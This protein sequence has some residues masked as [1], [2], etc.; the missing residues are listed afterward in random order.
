M[1]AQ[2]RRDSVA[3][4]VAPILQSA[5][6]DT[7]LML[8]DSEADDPRRLQQCERMEQTIRRLT[9]D[10]IP[11]LRLRGPISLRGLREVLQ[12]QVGMDLQRWR[13]LIKH[14]AEQAVDEWTNEG[15]DGPETGST[16]LSSPLTASNI[17]LD[18]NRGRLLFTQLPDE[19]RTVKSWRGTW[20]PL[21]LHG[22]VLKFTKCVTLKTVTPAVV[23]RA[24]MQAK[25]RVSGARFRTGRV[26]SVKTSSLEREFWVSPT[27]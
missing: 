18:C 5:M 2:N 7:A 23:N 13:T 4:L 21:T 24:N 15:R 16:C 8:R 22:T 14:C 1:W 27:V 6:W 20:E 19:I 3:L 12:C 9:F 26:P 17:C 25:S 11:Q 10:I